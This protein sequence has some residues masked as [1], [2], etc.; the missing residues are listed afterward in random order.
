MLKHIFLVHFTMIAA[1]EGDIS[2]ELMSYALSTLG[3][4]TARGWTQHFTAVFYGTGGRDGLILINVEA[5][6][7]GDGV[8]ADTLFRGYDPPRP[9]SGHPQILNSHNDVHG[10]LI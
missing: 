8:V 4:L 9:S 10:K 3:M 1:N 5:T 2:F 7:S 6:N